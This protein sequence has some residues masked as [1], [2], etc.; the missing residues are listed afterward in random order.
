[1]FIISYFSYCPVV[2]LFTSK[3][4][5]SKLDDIQ[6]RALRFVLNEHE[7]DYNDSLTMANVPGITIM[8]L[9]QLAIEVYKSFPRKTES[10]HHTV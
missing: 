10:E 1:M 9:R 4:S 2:W 3:S 7:S 5:L 6:K 8:T